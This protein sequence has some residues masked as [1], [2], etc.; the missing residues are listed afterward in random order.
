MSDLSD[1]SSRQSF[2]SG[3]DSSDSELVDH[4]Y[5]SHIFAAKKVINKGR[6]STE[7]DE[8]LRNLVEVKGD[9]DWKLVAN[10]FF[11]RSDIQCQHRWCKVLNPNLVKGA[12]TKEEDEK[13]IKLVREIGAKHWT[14]ISKHLQ[15]RTGKQCRERWHNHLNPEI[16]KS[17][18]TREEDILIY[19]LHR[20]LG[21]RWAEIAKYLPGRTD[22]A[23][24]NHW[25]STMKRKYE[26]RI[27]PA[28][29][30]GTFPGPVV[31][32]QPLPPVILLCPH[33]SP[34]SCS[35]T[36][37]SA[38]TQLLL[39]CLDKMYR[40]WQCWKLF[41]MDGMDRIKR[42]HPSLLHCIQKSTD[43]M[44]KQSR[45]WRV[46]GVWFP[47]LPLSPPSFPLFRLF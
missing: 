42:L 40:R 22:N 30:T 19:Q 11:D 45:S 41:R 27:P 13:V 47:S 18:W 35:Q 1:S 2:S 46:P 7:E 6:W 38:R 5:N 10:Y 26:E 8:K 23:I 28:D 29:F 37:R 12:W 21:N 3:E 16:K 20:S 31:S 14:Q 39:L 9:S 17:A 44:G 25:N 4:D 15:G 34:Y 32:G 43:L 36:Q 33:S 24:K